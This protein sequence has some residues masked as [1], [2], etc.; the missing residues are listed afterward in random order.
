MNSSNVKDNESWLLLFK[1]S[2]RRSFLAL[3]PSGKTIL[4]PRGEN[5]DHPGLAYCHLT[6]A[7]ALI[8]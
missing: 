2:A 6:D 7:T 4:D 5:L 1:H 3:G 8:S